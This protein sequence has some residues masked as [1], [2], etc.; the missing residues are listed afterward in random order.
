[1]EE[2][3]IRLE[4]NNVDHKSWSGH[5]FL[6]NINNQEH[7]RRLAYHCQKLQSRNTFIGVYNMV[8]T[9][10]NNEEQE[11]QIRLSNR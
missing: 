7:W 9:T 11:C 5:R 2:V 4:K 3:F 10:G 8:R 1:M 6:H